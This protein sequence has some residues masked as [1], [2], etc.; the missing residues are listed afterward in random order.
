MPIPKLPIKILLVPVIFV[1]IL[2]VGEIV[3]N[4][5]YKFPSNIE[6][7]VT[8]STKYAKYLKLDWKETYIDILDN[9][10][11]KNFRI[12]SYWDEVQQKEGEFNFEEI[13]F[14]VD[15]AEKRGVSII[16]V[17]GYKQ[18]RWPECHVP[19]W[20]RNLSVE[21]R[22]QKI[23]EFVKKTVERYE[24]KESISAWQVENEPLLPLFGEGCDP[25]DENFLKQE[26]D[27][28]RSLS[29]KQ[30][31]ISESGE[32]G[33]FARAMKLSDKLGISVYRK[34]H[35]PLLGYKIYPVLPYFYNIKSSLIKKLFAPQ[36]EKTIIAELQA[37]PWL[38]DGVFAQTPKEQ[39]EFFP[40]NEL[41]DYINYGKQTGFDEQYLWGVEWWYFMAQNGY[42]EYLEVVKTLSR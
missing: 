25:V 34:T 24:N 12:P 6:Y 19:S 7:G 31:I 27:L 32:F 20:A 26:V 37:E 23:L 16:L 40:V 29:K 15:A 33:F 14:L 13:D 11:V 4:K 1:V 3:F 21:Q 38:K 42:P 35:D 2:L 5:I 10:K 22:R 41:K 36:N 39:A 8:F 17:L 30:V 18:P 9:L 28:V